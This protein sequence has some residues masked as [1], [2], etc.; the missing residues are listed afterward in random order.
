METFYNKKKA[1]YKYNG[2]KAML[3]K[4]LITLSCIFPDS[5]I[6][7]HYLFIKWK[8]TLVLDHWLSSIK[9]SLPL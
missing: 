5:D 4:Y 8:I 2:N 3:I 7:I 1:N 6:D 9:L